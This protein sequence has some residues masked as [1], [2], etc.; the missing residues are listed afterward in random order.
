M[1][2]AALVRSIPDYPKAGILFRDITTLLKDRAGFRETIARLVAHYRDTG[3]EV[4][5]GIESRGFIIGAALACELNAGF[6]PLRKPGKLPAARIGEDYQLEYGMDRLEL[7]SDAI[8]PG[9]R[10][11]V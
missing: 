5:A 4:V 3:I 1:D 9:Q 7:H 2:L 8:V 11:L 6:V 10:V